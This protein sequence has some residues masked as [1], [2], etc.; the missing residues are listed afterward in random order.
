MPLSVSPTKTATL[1]HP[2]VLEG[3]VEEEE[4]VSTRADSPHDHRSVTE[5]MSNADEV[6][7]LTNNLTG[8]TAQ[9]AALLREFLIVSLHLSAINLQLNQVMYLN[10]ENSCYKLLQITLPITEKLVFSKR[11]Y[12]AM[13]S[14]I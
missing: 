9:N 2:G 4:G 12:I 5:G 13:E 10:K 7:D 1:T 14:S 8:L 3:I 11:S 6:H